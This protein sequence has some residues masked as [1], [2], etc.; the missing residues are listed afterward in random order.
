MKIELDLKQ[1]CQKPSI[2]EKRFPNRYLINS[3]F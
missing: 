2:E 1:I 3:Y